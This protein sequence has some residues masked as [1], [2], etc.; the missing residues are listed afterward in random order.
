MA[1]ALAV[2]AGPA[3]RAQPAATPL[4]PKASILVDADTGAVIA[5]TNSRAPL[6]P[7]SLTKIVTA[8]A[9]VAALEPGSSIPVS[10]RAAGMPAH[11][12]NMKEGQVWVVEDVLA[13][14][15]LS[16]ANDAG[17]AL[18]ERVSGTAEAFSQALANTARRL[19]MSDAP[20]LQDPSGLDDEFSVG[21]G[22]RI[23][24]RDLAIAARAVL[25]EPRLAP[26]VASPVQSFTGGDGIAHRL[27]NHN[28]LL[29]VYPGAIGMKTGYT[30]R[31]M[32][33][34]VAAATRNGRTMIAV[35]MGAPGDTYGLATAL[36]DAGFASA[37]GAMPLGDR[38]P[39]VAAAPT[40]AKAKAPAAAR[41]LGS[42]QVAAAS[43]EPVA[44][45]KPAA[46][47]T[48]FAN[49]AVFL[50]K[51]LL[52]FCVVA[53]ILRIRVNATH[54]E[55]LRT[56]PKG[57]R[58]PRQPRATPQIAT[59][60][61]MAPMMAAPSTTPE[62]ITAPT[63]VVVAPPPQRSRPLSAER[64]RPRPSAPR[65][66]RPVE[67][68]AEPEIDPKLARRFEILVRTGQVVP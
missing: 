12:L 63:P 16:S 21:G 11:N 46:G 47:G 33:G 29:K 8:L 3:A 26:L 4:P 14:L 40:P 27:G 43:L 64:R 60:P 61:A 31:S 20:V 51:V 57:Y 59:A 13:S 67:V 22:N 66:A 44:D 37:P 23:S 10:A 49:M 6:P 41:Q 54:R 48:S 39:A 62:P 17:M 35:V 1:F 68:E 28:R 53:A 65:R 19:G 2:V 30:R 5:G 7:A 56:R 18:A 25:T 34:L 52:A 24:A 9:A 50:F 32:H 55:Y 38:L 15:L 45:S 58:V 36:L 42:E